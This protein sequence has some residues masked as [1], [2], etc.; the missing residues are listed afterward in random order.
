MRAAWVLSPTTGSVAKPI[1][2]KLTGLRRRSG[3]ANSRQLLAS[4]AARALDRPGLWESLAEPG[5]VRA[6]EQ[7]PVR[8]LASRR[9]AQVEAQAPEA[10]LP[11][12]SRSALR[13]PSSP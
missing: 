8:A 6:L 2:T 11:E 9:A 10:A 1:R 13:S 12:R 4:C 5:P 3:S 7:A